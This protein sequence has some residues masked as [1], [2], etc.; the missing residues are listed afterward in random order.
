MGDS[1]EA[2]FGPKDYKMIEVLG[3][4]DIDGL[5]LSEKER[6]FLSTIFEDLDSR[7]EFDIK[8]V[9][10]PSDARIET[11]DK[12]RG[13]W[14][15]WLTDS[16][17]IGCVIRIGDGKEKHYLLH[18]WDG[19]WHLVQGQPPYDLPVFGL[20]E[21]RK[22][23]EAP[24]MIHEGPKAWEGAVAASSLFAQTPA[25]LKNWLSLYC[26]I[27]WH[28][29]DIGMEWTDWSVLRGR[30]VLIW[31]DMDEAG[32]ANARILGRR[33]ALMGG[34]VEYV[35][36]GLDDISAHESW[37]WGDPIRGELEN[38]TRSDVRLRIKRIESPVN[39]RGQI[40]D[41]WAKRSFLDL[42]RKEIYMISR[43]Y[44]PIPMDSLSIGKGKMFREKLV[45]SPINEFVGVDYRPGMEYG[46]MRDG[47]INMCPPHLREPM[48]PIPLPRKVYRE[49]RNGWLRKMVP[50]AA[51]RKHLIRRAAWAIARPNK[52]SQHMVVMQGSSGVGKSVFLD[53]LARVAGEDRAVSIF[54]DT[55]MSRFNAMVSFKSVVCVHEIHSNDLTRKQNASRLKELIA[56]DT[57]TTEEKNRPKIVHTNVIHWFAATNERL[58]FALEHGN[59]RFYFVRCEN[60][61]NPR[62]ERRKDKFFAK[63]LPRF[64]DHVFLDELYAASKWLCANM[65]AE[66]IRAMTGRAKRQSI[67]R[68]LENETLAPWEQFLLSRLEEVMNM[69]PDPIEEHPPV[70][71]GGRIIALVMRDFRNA[72]EIRI[73]DRM[74]E[75]GYKVLRNEKGAPVG[76]KK[77]GTQHR[78]Y[79]WCR[80]TDEKALQAWGSPQT[81]VVRGES[82]LLPRGEE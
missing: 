13:R 24:V 9:R 76:R 71:F 73:R 54:P 51:Q 37:D 58:P 18:I 43:G 1:D 78:E 48:E 47:R 63:W 7:S 27:G 17:R 50:D 11:M 75:F 32:L 19:G 29:S 6:E 3:K 26:H 40:T 38:L 5:W 45:E 77:K 67:W 49:I 52:V 61:K 64:H 70:F 44:R 36:W 34:V 21:L 62:E 31:P 82:G 42:E 72:G 65:G 68:Y 39:A 79:L 30:R 53:L 46:R 22:R 23:P 2:S 74:V 12:E 16:Q 59:D 60:P 28:G 57:I 69:E 14:D 35:Q 8:D 25:R 20:P 33:I 81:L 41:E 55:I 56:N 15:I 80:A 10:A 4:V 66:Q